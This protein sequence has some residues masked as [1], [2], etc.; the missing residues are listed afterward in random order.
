MGL[1][2]IVIDFKLEGGG[3]GELLGKDY[4]FQCS[5]ICT[6]FMEITTS[7]EH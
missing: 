6:N 5:Q 4:D 3:G 1:K 7:L 2:C